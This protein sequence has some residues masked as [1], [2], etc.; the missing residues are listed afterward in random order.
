MKETSPQLEV[1]QIGGDGNTVKCE[2]L[3]LVV[4]DAG[5]CHCESALQGGGGGG[6]GERRNDEE[7]E[8]EK[9]TKRN[10]SLV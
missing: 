6:G 8:E 9:M 4:A 5:L 10:F 7:K 3:S 1:L 2:W